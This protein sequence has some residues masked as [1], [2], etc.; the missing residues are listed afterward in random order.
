MSIEDAIAHSSFFPTVHR[1]EKGGDVTEMLNKAKNRISG[2]VRIGGQEHF[3]LETNSCIIVPTGENDELTV[4][5]S[6]QNPTKMQEMLAHVLGLQQNRVVVKV[7]R[8]GG[9]FGGKETRSFHYASTVAVA[10]RKLNRPVK[11]NIERDLDMST[12]GHRH[13]FLSKHKCLFFCFNFS[14]IRYRV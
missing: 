8:I 10:A 4:Y 11:L 14:Q 7:K 3:Y 13:P 9:G 5:S 12:S 2:E 1:V 6:T